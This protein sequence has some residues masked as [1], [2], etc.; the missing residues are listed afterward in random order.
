[1]AL[2]FFA[3]TLFV[4]AFILFLVQPIIGKLILP[5]LGGTPQVWNTCMVFFQM[6][7]LAGYAYTHAVST[8]FDTKKQILIHL[9]LLLVPIAILLPTPFSIAGFVPPPGANPIPYTLYY[10]TLVVGLPFFVV[11]TSAP[12]LQKWFVHTGH[13]AARDPYFLYGASNLG[14][15]LALLA[16]PVIV[17]P[18]FGLRADEFDLGKQNWLWTVSYGVLIVLVAGCAALVFASPTS[19]QLPGKREEKEPEL[20]AVGMASVPETAPAASATAATSAAVT[21]SAPLAGAA[22]S[23]AIKKGGKQK[24]Q[25]RHREQPKAPVHSGPA[26]VIPGITHPKSDEVTPA[27]R[28]RWVLLAAVPSSLMLGATTYMSTDVAAIPLFWVIPLALYLLSFIFVFSRWPVPWTGQPHAATLWIQPV[29]LA[30][31]VAAIVIT[32]GRDPGSNYLLVCAIIVLAFFAT[33]LVCHG[34]MA[35]DRPGT[36]HL[37][38]FYLWMS[39]GGMVGGMF[40]GLFAP[41]APSF[42]QGLFPGVWEFGLTLVVAALIRPYLVGSGWVDQAITNILNPEGDKRVPGRS[43][44]KTSEPTEALGYGLDVGVAVFVVLLMLLLQ[45][46]MPKISPDF[47]PLAYI[48][49][50]ALACVSMGR[51]LR[52]GLA[53]CLV[54]L[55]SNFMLRDRSAVVAS[56][57]SYFGILEVHK[58]NEGYNDF[59]AGKAVYLPYMSLT[60]GTTHHGMNFTDKAYRRLATTYYHRFG[61]AGIAM[62]KFNW[63]SFVGGE[64]QSGAAPWNKYDFAD[65]RLPLSVFG[66]VTADVMGMN[67]LPLGPM[68]SAWSEPPYAVIGLGTGTMA[69]YARPFQHVTFYEI[70]ERVRRY[71]LTPDENRRY[72]TY[73]YDA[74]QRGA[75]V[76]MV[77]GDARLS[78]NQEVAQDDGIYTWKAGGAMQQSGEGPEKSDNFKNHA[79]REGYY[80]LIIVDAFTSDA[81]PVHLLTKEAIDMYMS[82][83]TTDGVLCIHTS[84]R[85]L[86]LVPVV[87]KIC[88]EV[89]L[90]WIDSKGKERDQI[91]VCKRGHDNAYGNQKEL[92]LK[93]DLG[94]STSEWV[95]V[96]RDSEFLSHLQKPAEYKEK[97]DMLLKKVGANRLGELEEYWSVP[98]ALHTTWTDDYSNLL[99][100]FRWP[101]ER[102]RLR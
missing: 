92:K 85:H 86:E 46:L 96:A 74:V 30:A 53:V 28:F 63:A 44:R 72:F 12:L 26:P 97:Y 10:L 61:P 3:L 7:L 83:L 24:H 80:H 99:A 64:L 59:D 23:T 4:S 84:N 102:R 60:H 91:L 58:N 47:M 76:E 1:L 33:A 79:K 38:E 71:S 34:E 31:L 73:L 21:A 52:F 94:H 98:A 55:V 29:L 100:V 77:M 18:L 89:K 54:L 51:P 50:L 20:A 41:M 68:V 2:P 13:P 101:W 11:S 37:T 16:Y 43:I 62:E 6:V 95:M 81:I 19:V 69:S 14:S 70:D 22:K 48:L 56:E 40:N 66:S 75:K 36:K 15:M 57:R 42:F 17:E 25:H 88:Q 27:R 8:Y 82:K 49:P 87:A 90:K 9:F 32:G 78:M 65:A 45:W 5:R 35:K 39:V 93:Q 67:L